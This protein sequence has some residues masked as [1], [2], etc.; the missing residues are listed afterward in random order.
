MEMIQ[1]DQKNNSQDKIMWW[2][3]DTLKLHKFS[4]IYRSTQEYRYM[5]I[6]W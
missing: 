5:Q 4:T 3:S 6:E 2:R 1:E